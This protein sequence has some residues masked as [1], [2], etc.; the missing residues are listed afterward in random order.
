MKF[1]PATAGNQVT[2]SLQQGEE[3]FLCPKSMTNLIARLC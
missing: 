2:F 1:A 3:V